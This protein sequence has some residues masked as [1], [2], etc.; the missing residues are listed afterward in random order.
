MA[1]KDDYP[2][3]AKDILQEMASTITNSLKNV[4][5]KLSTKIDRLVESNNIMEHSLQT[6][7]NDAQ[8]AKDS[9][10]KLK[11][12]VSSQENVIKSQ[13]KLIEEA[14]AYSKRYNLKFFL[15]L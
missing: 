7:L 9:T 14:Q 2:S 10:M 5:D 8:F 15:T 4:I 13:A 12:R 3:W 11:A 1:V 6:A